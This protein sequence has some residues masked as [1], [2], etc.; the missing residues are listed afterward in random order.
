MGELTN[1]VAIVTGAS[2][3]IGRA[4]AA[5]FSDAGAAVV[6]AARDEDRLRKVAQ[7]SKGKTLVVRTDVTQKGDCERLIETTMREFRKLDVLVNAAGIIKTG[8]IENTSLE[9][10]DA[11]FNINVRSVF[12]LMRLAVPHL[13][14]SK[15]NI[16]NVSSVN[17]LRSFPGVL[18]YCSSKAALD[19]LTR[20]AS[21]ELASKGVRVN[22]V[23]PGVVR[24]ELHR[25][26]GMNE[27]SYAKF[28]EHSSQN[29]HPLGRIGKP[30]EVAD[31][32][33]FL[34]SDRAA[35]ITG[36]NYSI[37]GGRADTC[38]R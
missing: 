24:T 14:K 19:H 2:S 37:D 16:V 26:G 38:L 22:S 6:L 8:S 20:C 27:E 32:I 31:L 13:I 5:A 23:N 4:T 3:G 33:L 10:W 21:L 30:E 17:G 36:A 29:T 9:D 12:Y 7:E 34:A 1:R 35:W 11:L 18:A 15:G 25:R 28:V